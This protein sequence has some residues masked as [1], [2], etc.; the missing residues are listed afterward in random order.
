[1]LHYDEF[2]ADLADALL[3]IARYS[4]F[5]ITKEK[6]EAA[7]ECARN[8]RAQLRFN[9]GVGGRDQ[10]YFTQDH[11]IRIAA[12]LAAYPHVKRWLPELMGDAKAPVAYL[13][14]RQ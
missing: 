3:K 13:A 6:C 7:P 5:E 9:K 11:L 1:V 2:R 4:G 10:T 8:E 14:Q 12:M